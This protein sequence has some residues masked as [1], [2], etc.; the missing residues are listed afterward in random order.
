MKMLKYCRYVISFL[1]QDFWN[2][3]YQD[4]LMESHV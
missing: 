2:D 1:L 4:C 3:G